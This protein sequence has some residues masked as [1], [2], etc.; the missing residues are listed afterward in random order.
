MECTIS[1]RKDSYYQVSWVASDG[2]TSEIL[3]PHTLVKYTDW[4]KEGLPLSSQLG[5]FGWRD[6]GEPLALDFGG[7]HYQHKKGLL[8]SS[9]LGGFGW[10]DIGDTL[11]PYFGEVHDTRKDSHCQ[12][13]WVASDGVTSE[14]HLP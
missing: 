13:S 12:V 2:V 14:N 9:Q 3:L 7:M 8:S 1:T 4:H 10:R 5:G 11:A 6:I